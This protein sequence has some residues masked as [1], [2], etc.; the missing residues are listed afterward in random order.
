MWE[1]LL[2]GEARDGFGFSLKGRVNDIGYQS[3][4]VPGTVAGL[5]RMHERH[6]KLPWAE[7]IAPAI[8]WARDGF[9]VRPA[10]HA[11]WI[12]E[13][14]PGRASNRERLAYTPAGRELYCR[15]DGSPKTI[16]TPLRNPD[17]AQVL[18]QLARE[19]A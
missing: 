3:V 18:E 8:A 2:E 7:V 19:G 6:G 14:L 15:P 12:D 16:G 11:F 13:T 9:F 5:K 1:H 10:M 17:F 4:A